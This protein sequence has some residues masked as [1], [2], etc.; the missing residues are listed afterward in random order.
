MNQTGTLQTGN[1][2][3]TIKLN[4][5]GFALDENSARKQTVYFLPTR[6]N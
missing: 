1:I 6:L 4:L 5:N 3:S 2:E